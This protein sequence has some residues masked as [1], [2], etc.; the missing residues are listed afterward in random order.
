MKLPVM[1]PSREKELQKNPQ[2][3]LEFKKKYNFR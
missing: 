1:A 3:F 2:I